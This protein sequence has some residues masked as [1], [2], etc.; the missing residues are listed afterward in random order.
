MRRERYPLPDAP[1]PMPVK[2]PPELSGAFLPFSCSLASGNDSQPAAAN[3][4]GIVIRHKLAAAHVPEDIGPAVIGHIAEASCQSRRI[5]QSG[6]GREGD[7]D[8]IWRPHHR[9]QPAYW[10]L[11]SGKP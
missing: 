8:P 4:L 10:P 9:Q 5:E 1:F 2:A 7:K 6:S 3:M 11:P